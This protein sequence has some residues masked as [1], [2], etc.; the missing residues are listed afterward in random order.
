MIISTILQQVCRQAGFVELD[1]KEFQI[2]HLLLVKDLWGFIDGTEVLQDK[3]ST[4]QQAEFNKRSQKTFSTVVMSVNLSQLYFITSYK[5][6]RRAE[7]TLMEA[8]I[9]IMKELIDRLV[10]INAPISEEDQVV[11]LLARKLTS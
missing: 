11:T 8:H 5:D 3:G 6:P 2:K 4:Q 10:A 1:D 7:G 9:K